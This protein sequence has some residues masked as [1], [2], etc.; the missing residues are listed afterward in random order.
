MVEQTRKAK[1]LWPSLVWFALILLLSTALSVYWLNHQPRAARGPVEPKIALVT[2]L[3]P[4]PMAFVPHIQSF[5]PVIPAHSVELNARVEGIVLATGANYIEGGR[6]KRGEELIRLDPTD[7][8]LRLQQAENDRVKAQFNLKLELGQQA[9]A[10]LDYKMLGD[11]LDELGTQLVLRKPHLEASKSALSAAEALLSQ[12]RIN[13]QRTRISAPF[14]AVVTERNAQVGSRVTTA[15]AGTPLARL[16]ATDRFWIDVSLPVDKLRWLDIPDFNSAKGSSVK[17]YFDNGWGKD[18]YREGVIKRLKA[19]VEPES[20]MAKLIVEVEDPLALQPENR[21]W[22]K[23]MLNTLVRVEIQGKPLTNVVKLP[24]NVVHEG[25][26]L[27]L[28]N[29]QG[30]LDIAAIAPLWHE[31]GQ[32]FIDAEQ[33]PAGAQVVANNLPAPVPGMRLRS[34]AQTLA[35]EVEPAHV[36]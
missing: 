32:V 3:M 7:Y 33:L 24:E 17:I 16:V 19:A 4:E 14:D 26:K 31:R 9:V 36:N 34:D 28:M 27:W 2:T 1:K 15:S 6:V 12:A 13:L 22:P 29:H 20:R 25:D 23:M 8:Q 30:T 18:R 21:D 11:N 35:L 5:G 10:K